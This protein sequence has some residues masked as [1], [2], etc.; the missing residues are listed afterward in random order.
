MTPADRR[1][2]LSLVED[3]AFDAAFGRLD[4]PGRDAA[5]WRLLA[6]AVA[7]DRHGSGAV[8]A[9]PPLAIAPPARLVAPRVSRPHRWLRPAAV[10]SGL[11]F[12]AVVL[13]AVHTPDHG[14]PALL[15]P[16]GVGVGVVLQA[17][18]DLAVA[19]KTPAGTA[20]LDPNT[21]YDVGDTL[22][23]QVTLPT[24]AT[25]ELRR[26]AGAGDGVVLWRG[27][28]AAGQQTIPAGYALD[29]GDGTARF[30]VTATTVDGPA[31]GTVTV[32]APRASP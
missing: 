4:L 7:E 3:D 16:K 21:A 23:F 26:S 14:D 25:V 6:D 9:L 18:L 29:P 24:P 8:A 27:D 10:A 11:A 20:R 1:R 19:V 12:A 31:V 2:A 32:L 22:V 15:V 13:F 17:P 28:L 30:V 5:H